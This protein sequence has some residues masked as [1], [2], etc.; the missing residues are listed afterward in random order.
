MLSQ[1]RSRIAV[2]VAILAAR[3]A[4]GSRAMGSAGIL[5]RVGQAG[6][7]ETPGRNGQSHGQ[8]D[9]TAARCCDH[10]ADLLSRDATTK[11][12]RDGHRRHHRACLDAMRAIYASCGRCL[13]WIEGQGARSRCRFLQQACH[14]T[15]LAHADP[16]SRDGE[17]RACDLSFYPGCFCPGSQIASAASSP[18]GWP[19]MGH[20]RRYHNPITAQCLRASQVSVGN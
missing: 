20:W 1:D 12:H 5:W 11:R 3:G 6:A 16:R 19:F 8:L 17:T 10:E 13:R 2:K 9:P 7:G 14:A 4:T 15:N 18:K